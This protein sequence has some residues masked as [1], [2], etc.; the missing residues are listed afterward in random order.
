MVRRESCADLAGESPG[1]VIA[2]EPVSRVRSRV[3]RSVTERIVE[4]LRREGATKRAATRVNAEQA[5]SKNQPKGDR[6]S[7]ASHVVAKA[8]HSALRV[9]EGALGLPGVVAAA[10]LDRTARNTGDPSPQ[11]KSG[12]AIRIRREPK[13]NRAGRKSEGLV[14]PEKAVRS[15]WRKGALL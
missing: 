11:P 1:P 9:P 15:R 7:R 2:G 8:K 3:E 4:S 6:E 12:K 14:V 13:S 5:S 10:R